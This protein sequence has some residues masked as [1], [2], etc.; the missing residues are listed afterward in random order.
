MTLLITKKYKVNYYFSK[1][2]SIS[3]PIKERPKTKKNIANP[4][5]KA[6][7]HIP[8]GSAARARLRSLPHSGTSAGTPKP[9]KPKLPNT[10]TASAA[11]KVR[12]MGNGVI[13]FGR[14]YLKTIVLTSAPET[15]AASTYVSD[16]INNVWFL[17]N[18]K[19]WGE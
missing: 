7:H 10:K 11:F 8:V 19:Y 15:L 13:T 4:G 9:K 12:R 14:I 2:F 6:V 5:N 1:I 16:F 17:I 3:S 18:L